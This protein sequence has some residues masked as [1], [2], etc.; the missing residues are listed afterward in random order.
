MRRIWVA[1][2]VA[3]GMLICG[4]CSRNRAKQIQVGNTYRISITL[5]PNT[6]P[7]DCK[8]LLNLDPKPTPPSGSTANNLILIYNPS[9]DGIGDA[10]RWTDATQP[11]SPEQPGTTHRIVVTFAAAQ[12]NSPFGTADFTAAGGSGS[13]TSPPAND[14]GSLQATYLYEILYNAGVDANGKNVVCL[15]DPMIIVK[16]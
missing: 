8:L 6:N 10:V 5:Q 4:A 2:A 11:P 1:N 7:T 12:S 9:G 13:I 3:L 14:P 16:R 15:V